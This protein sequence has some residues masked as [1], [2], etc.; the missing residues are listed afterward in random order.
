MNSIRSFV[1]LISIVIGSFAIVH[2]GGENPGTEEKETPDQQA[3]E[4][5]V[6]WQ[7]INDA[8]GTSSSPNYQ[9]SYSAG[10]AVAGLSVSTDYQVGMG[11]WF[12]AISTL[13]C[14][15]GLIGDVNC[16]GTLNPLDMQFLAQYVFMSM[17]VLCDKPAC[18]NPTG[19]AN[20]NEIVDAVDVQVLAKYVFTP[21]DDRCSPC[22][23]ETLADN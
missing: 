5:S 11:Y 20:C 18:P 21:I 8:G 4:Y 16:D 22:T 12:G 15:C 7:G 1:I 13:P 14:D 3:K 9:V 10:G 19:D 23:G 6:P 17:E 2:A